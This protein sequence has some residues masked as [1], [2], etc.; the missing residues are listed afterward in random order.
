[1]ILFHIK[2]EKAWKLPFVEITYSNSTSEICTQGSLAEN[3]REECEKF[4]GCTLLNSV[5]CLSIETICNHYHELSVFFIQQLLKCKKRDIAY[6]FTNKQGGQC[7]ESILYNLAKLAAE[8]P[9]ASQLIIDLVEIAIEDF[10]RL[11]MNYSGSHFLRCLGRI[12]C[13]LGKDNNKSTVIPTPSEF[14]SSLVNMI[15]AVLNWPS[16]SGPYTVFSS[17]PK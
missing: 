3:C 4:D 7:L 14:H 9:I 15:S 1:M 6:I 10:D 8:K 17:V 2:H 13:G 12:L 5:A 11:N 16:I